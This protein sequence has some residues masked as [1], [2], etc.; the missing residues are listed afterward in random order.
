MRKKTG[1]PAFVLIH[2]WVL[3][4]LA[5]SSTEISWVGPCSVADTQS[6]EN[7]HTSSTCTVSSSGSIRRAR[8]SSVR[9]IGGR[10]VS[11]FCRTS[12][13]S[14]GELRPQAFPLP[15]VANPSQRGPQAGQAADDGGRCTDADC[16]AGPDPNGQHALIRHPVRRQ[17]DDTRIDL[18]SPCCTM[19]KPILGIEG[20][21]C[22]YQLC[23]EHCMRSH[24]VMMSA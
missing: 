22:T 6:G 12:T 8:S 24:G 7:A 16:C 3:I 15:E 10:G 19:Y 4:V 20:R 2:G 23:S 13:T 1:R 17:T 5:W 11:L 14:P 9:S 18:I 21:L